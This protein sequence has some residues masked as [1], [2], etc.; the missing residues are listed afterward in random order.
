MMRFWNTDPK[1]NATFAHQRVLGTD[2]KEKPPHCC[3][4]K[5][6]TKKMPPLHSNSDHRLATRTQTQPDSLSNCRPWPSN[7]HTN[8][9]IF[10]S[11]SNTH[12]NPATF[13]FIYIY[14]DWKQLNLNWVV[15]SC[16]TIY[17][18][19]QHELNCILFFNYTFT[20]PI[21][22]RSWD[23]DGLCA[24]R[25]GFD[26]GQGEIFLFSTASRLAL[27]PTQPPV[28]WVPGA[29]FPVVKLLGRGADYS[30]P[31]GA[32][33]KNG[34]AIPPVPHMSSWHSA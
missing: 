23:S 31:S 5:P 8:P 2:P 15:F 29:I 30:L 13:A 14:I 28:Q 27:R 4:P 16:M 21:Y 7:T 3:A 6:T 24:G 19:A 1:G 20:L 33:V 22:N 9:A 25:P 17:A 32:E 11:P 12:T 18:Q 34:G 26:S 10:A